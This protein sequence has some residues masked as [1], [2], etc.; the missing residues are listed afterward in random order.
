MQNLTLGPHL[1]PNLRSISWTCS[2]WDSA[3]LLRL[4]LNP[5]LID[6]EI[7][8]PNSDPH[9]YRPATISLIPARSLTNLKLERMAFSDPLPTDELHNLLEQASETL[10]SVDLDGEL[11]GTIIEKLLQLPN[12]RRLDIRMPGTRIALPAVVL[13]SL[14]E[15]AVSCWEDASWLCVLRNIQSPALRE[16]DISF[17]GD[18]PTYLQTFGTSLLDARIEQ[19]LIS[20]DLAS[21]AGIPLTEAGLRPF[22]SFRKLTKLELFSLCTTWHCSFRLNDSII[23]KLAVAL[24]RLTHLGLGGTPCETS[25]VDVTIASLVALSINCVDLDVLRLHFN[26]N[27]IVS[28][29]ACENSQTHKF[30]CK[31]RTLIVGSQPLPSNHDDILLLTFTILHVFPHLEDITAEGQ[32]WGQVGQGVHLFKKAQKIIPFPTTN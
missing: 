18:S 25:T 5:E 31:L 1:F 29:D 16:L 6:V 17:S 13:P 2:S 8:F 7:G 9:I 11:S 4:F 14:E 3:P 10:R 23:S 22:I 32:G 19:T 26:V 28:R 30:T 27:D 24:P 21:L 15:L 20:L 12:L